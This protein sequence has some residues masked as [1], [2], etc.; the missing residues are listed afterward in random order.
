MSND[1][2]KKKREKMLTRGIIEAEEKAVAVLITKTGGGVMAIEADTVTDHAADYVDLR[3]LV[4]GATPL[5]W[6]H[7]KTFNFIGPK[8]NQQMCFRVSIIAEDIAHVSEMTEDMWE[9]FVQDQASRLL[10]QERQATEQAGG[11][12]QVPQM[13]H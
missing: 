13:L 11:G 9:K 1:T 10:Q 5:E 12:I 3:R 7:I 6:L 2:E 4:E 8:A